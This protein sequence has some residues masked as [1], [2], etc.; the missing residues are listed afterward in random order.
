MYRSFADQVY[1]AVKKD[2]L[3]GEHHLGSGIA[4][5]QP[6]ERFTREA[7]QNQP[8]R[9]GTNP[10]SDSDTSL[11]RFHSRMYAGS[12]NCAQL[13]EA[14]APGQTIVQVALQK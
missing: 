1:E 12:L 11:P 8:E 7:L 14:A 2:I 9:N 5:C 3:T 6:A 10:S 13:L 4:P